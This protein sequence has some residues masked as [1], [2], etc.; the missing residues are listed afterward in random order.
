MTRKDRFKTYQSNHKPANVVSRPFDTALLKKRETP[1]PDSELAALRDQF[2]E[3]AKRIQR[4]AEARSVVDW[5]AL[6]FILQ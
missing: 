3:Q 4:D 1:L 6:D 2:R 5:Q